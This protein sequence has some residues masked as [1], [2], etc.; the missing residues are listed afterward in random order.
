[1]KKV[2]AESDFFA[3]KLRNTETRIVLIDKDLEN[4]LIICKSKMEEIDRATILQNQ[5][6]QEEASVT[7]VLKQEFTLYE[8]VST[9]LVKVDFED[10]ARL[11]FPDF[12]LRIAVFSYAIFFEVLDRN[13][14]MDPSTACNVRI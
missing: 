2:G 1:M 4:D 12:L 11:K 7:K 6:F 13:K 10:I 8:K 9:K 3:E 5:A 14:F